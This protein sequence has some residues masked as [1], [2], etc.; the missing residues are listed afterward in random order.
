MESRPHKDLK[1]DT[2]L[3][4]PRTHEFRKVTEKG[5]N[6]KIKTE[7]MEEQSGFN[8]G[9]AKAFDEIFDSSAPHGLSFVKKTD[10]NPSRK[11]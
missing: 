11:V 4:W 3:K 9:D 2:K 6:L 7:G 8:P 5:S 10:K 1:P